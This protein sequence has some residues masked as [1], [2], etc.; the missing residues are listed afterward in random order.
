MKKSIKSKILS[1]ALALSL[2]VSLVSSGVPLFGDMEVTVLAASGDELIAEMNGMAAEFE[3]NLAEAQAIMDVGG[4]LA[5]IETPDLTVIPIAT[6]T[7]LEKISNDPD[8]PLSGSYVLTAD[9]DLS[10]AEW[11]PIGVDENNAFTGTFDGQGYKIQNL[12][13]TGSSYKYVGLFGYVHNGTIKNVG[14]ID[15]CIDVTLDS[16][17][18]VGGIVG[19]SDSSSIENCYNTGDVS[20]SSSYSSS[21]DRIGD[22]VNGNNHHNNEG[23]NSH[24]TIKRRRARP[25]RTDSGRVHKHSGYHSEAERTVFR[26]TGENAGS[27]NGRTPRV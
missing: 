6:R 10:G 11:T 4:F 20:S 26:N 8:Y 22:R 23:G 7:D 24:D 17:I 2:I 13:I 14:M 15:T 12:M 21:R 18:Y 3:E 19:H 1:A 9:I 5:P 25:G 16:D 27:G